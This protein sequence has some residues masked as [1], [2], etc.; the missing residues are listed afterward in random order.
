[1]TVTHLLTSET[2]FHQI[3]YLTLSIYHSPTLR[4]IAVNISGVD[5]SVYCKAYGYHLFLEE[6]VWF[7]D[8]LMINS[9][10]KESSVASLAFGAQRPEPYSELCV[11]LN[12]GGKNATIGR[13][14]LLVRSKS[15]AW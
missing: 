9:Y 14:V 13:L 1:M 11:Q 10:N 15:L 7:Q 6:G 5:T 8:G 3:R 4:V 12:S 2:L